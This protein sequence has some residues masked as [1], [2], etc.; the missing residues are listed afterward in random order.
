MDNCH[1]GSYVRVGEGVTGPEKAPDPSG[2]G[3][4]EGFPQKKD[5]EIEA[6]RASWSW[7]CRDGGDEGQQR[8]DQAQVLEG[9]GE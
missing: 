4:S 9:E 6:R 7:P 2:G 3:A 8:G 5:L 1:Q